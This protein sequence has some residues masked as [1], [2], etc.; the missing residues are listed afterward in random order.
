VFDECCP[1]VETSVKIEPFVGMGYTSV[2]SKVPVDP[3]CDDGMADW[4]EPLWGPSGR[5]DL[6][7]IK[8]MGASVVRTYGVGSHLNHS[9]FLDHAEK[10]GLKVNP[11]FADWTYSDSGSKCGM[12]RVVELI[13]NCVNDGVY[14]CH[15]VIKN[16]YAQ[17]LKNG[18]TVEGKDGK[19]R[20]HSALQTITLMNEC[21]LK[22]ESGYFLHGAG[23]PRGLN[24]Y[25]AKVMISALD[26]LLSAEDDLDI[27]GPR[28]L[29][30]STVSYSTCPECKSVLGNTLFLGNKS[31]FPGLDGNIPFLAY[32]ADYFLAIQDPVGFVGYTPKHDNLLEVY[33]NRWINSFNTGNA[34]VELCEEQQQ[35]IH[36]YNSG[37]LGKIPI[38]I[39]EFHSCY[40]T[41][42][43]FGQDVTNALKVIR[44]EPGN[45]CQEET[46]TPQSLTGFNAFEFQVSYWKGEGAE[47]GAATKFGMWGL[48]EASLAKTHSDPASIG[49][50]EFEV[51]CLFPAVSGGT[52]PAQ[53]EITN[54][55]R[56]IDALG[57]KWPS[58]PALCAGYSP[59]TSST[60]IV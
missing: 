8:D 40:E 17:M 57:G 36:L 43:Q 55:E 51:S 14:D 42:E 45:A 13:S 34:F 44:G 38:Y 2:P 10:V 12:D 35:V 9:T 24:A 30:T 5:N 1:Q 7:L 59:P 58:Q 28:P 11:G 39:G 3:V 50:E 21:E 52:E 18:Y 15:D 4:S 37:P 47:G 27:V 48:G 32:V 22:L 46:G 31:A 56:V 6:Q 41:P 29:L 16:H 60:L 19:L 25:H 54:V 33:Q 23:Q 49:D 53:G 20:Y 26:G